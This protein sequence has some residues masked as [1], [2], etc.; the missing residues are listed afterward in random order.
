MTLL[1]TAST[2]L[3]TIAAIAAVL[4]LVDGF[5]TGRARWKEL[6]Q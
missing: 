4:V 3:F 6:T 1:A 2:I 5:I